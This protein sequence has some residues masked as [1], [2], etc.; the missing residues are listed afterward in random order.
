MIYPTAASQDCLQTGQEIP[1]SHSLDHQAI[2]TQLQRFINP[3]VRHATGQK[4]HG[5]QIS[6]SAQ[7]PKDVQSRA[8]GH[9]EI[10]QDKI[11]TDR[12]ELIEKQ[13]SVSHRPYYL[14]N[15]SGK[16]QFD[17][18]QGKRVILRNHY[19]SH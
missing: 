9:V 1:R 14:V 19:T 8:L 13:T 7:R 12:G 16:E 11:G 18:L 4:H 5:P 3:L 2:Q 6:P 15:R 17:A 10:K